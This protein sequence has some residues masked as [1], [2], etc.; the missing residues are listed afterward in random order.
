MTAWMEALFTRRFPGISIQGA[1][2]W[3]DRPR[4]VTALFGPSGCG[5]STILR[6]LAGLERPDSGFIRAFGETWSDTSNSIHMPPQ[7]RRVGFLFQD[8][9]L[10]PHLTVYGNVSFGAPQTKDSRKQA[11][12]LL[13]RFQ[14]Q[15][16][17]ERRPRELSGGQQQRVA[18]ARA[19]AA[20]PRLLCLD[21]PLSAL[22]GPMRT[23]LR[24][25]LRGW[26][27]E[28]QLPALIVSHDAV[29]VQSLADDVI[30][31]SQGSFRQIGSVAEVW[32]QPLNTTVAR[33]VGFDNLLPVAVI[34][35]CSPTV[36]TSRGEWR[37]RG[38]SR[39]HLIAG[40]SAIACIRAEDIRCRL[41]TGGQIPDAAETRVTI[42]DM[43]PDGGM[44]RLKLKGTSDDNLQSVVPRDTVAEFAL[45][46]NSEVL[47]SVAPQAAAIV[48]A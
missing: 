34:T 15:G 28:A 26:L 41:A 44:W 24:D 42:I 37:I 17:G 46:P 33:I 43:T 39:E 12:E 38:V 35:S 3:H 23:D 47:I 45:R 7:K 22:D 1:W 16:L 19:L 29:D 4:R 21:E 5:K 13:D 18:L 2:A 6:C 11:D 27:H 40:Q 10:F 30:V 36:E 8:Y 48:P 31:L 32:H 14:L 20:R 25:A 9:M